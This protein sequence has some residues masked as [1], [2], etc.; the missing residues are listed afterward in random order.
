M[1]IWMK[2]LGGVLVLLVATLVAGV[3]VLKSTDYNQF[4]GTIDNLVQD[5]TGRELSISGDLQLAVSLTPTLYVTGVTF[6]NADW[7]LDTP[8]ITLQRLEAQVALK[9]L[10]SGRLEIDHIVLDGL[11]LVLQTDGKGKANWEFGP[12]TGAEATVSD[13]TLVLEPEVHDV[14]LRDV[15]VTYIDGAMGAKFETDLRRADFMAGGMDSP[16]KGVIEAVYNGVD[17][18]AQAE[19]GSL[20]QLIGT[21]GDAF[22]VNL[23]ISGPGLLTD[24]IG[25]V[26]QPSAGMAVETRVSAQVSDMATAAKLAGVELPQ[27]PGLKLRAHV[28]GGGTN[29]S[30][31]GLE[32]SVG[33]SD[34]KG[35]GDVELGGK[36]PRIVATLSSNTLDVNELA[37]LKKAR[38]GDTQ[39]DRMFSDDPLPFEVLQLIDGDV[40]LTVKQ[41]MIDALAFGDVKANAHLKDG[42]LVLKPLSLTFNKGHINTHAVVDGQAKTPKLNIRASVRGLD[43]NSFAALAGR[44]GLVTLKLDGEVKVKSSGQSLQAIMGGLNGTTNFVGRNGRIFDDRFKNLTEG[45]G[46]ILPWAS[47]KDANVISCMV[48]K[49][50]IVNG[51]AR[52]ETVM[53]D[54]SGVVVKITGNADLAGELLH[55]TVHTD[56]KKP[57]SPVLPCRFASKVRLSN[58]ALMSIRVM[59]WSVRWATSSRPQPN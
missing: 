3:A 24:I 44:D 52:A 49:V 48:A 35:Q 34:L 40:Q 26:E 56:A 23:K 15:H 12:V 22:P 59:W 5:A 6:A 25:S 11:D 31:N 57:A 21:K 10:L 55:L 53:L 46:S 30:I 47:S 7:A 1:K 13:G 50:P 19:L 14:R 9:P 32:A 17:L 27:W 41:V 2:V 39:T 33:G 38:S 36:R 20:G 29:F 43:A 58:R 37:D 8:M 4:K 45:V 42:K 28:S 54:T 51:D 18:E 16:L